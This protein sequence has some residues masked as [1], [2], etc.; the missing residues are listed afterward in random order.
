M[1]SLFATSRS[2]SSTATGAVVRGK[3]KMT[4][5][6]RSYSSGMRTFDIWLFATTMK[7][8][9]SWTV[10]WVI[11]ISRNRTEITVDGMDSI[12]ASS[13]EEALARASDLIDKWLLGDPRRSP[14]ER[15][16]TPQ[17]PPA[18]AK[19]ATQRTRIV[20]QSGQPPV[21]HYRCEHCGHLFSRTLGEE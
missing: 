9:G 12:V 2:L 16:P 18:C 17:P 19:C 13:E 6:K 4:T 15:P 5:V 10:D 8:Y 3:V 7:G 11:E 14:E 20:G 21:V 1:E